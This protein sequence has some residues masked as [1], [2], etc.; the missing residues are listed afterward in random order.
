MQQL[1]HTAHVGMHETDIVA[2]D[3]KSN[4]QQGQSKHL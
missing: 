4:K 2:F 3:Q 1:T